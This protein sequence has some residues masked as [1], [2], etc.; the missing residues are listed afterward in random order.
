[1]YVMKQ[2]IMMAAIAAL[3]VVGAGGH[4]NVKAD[5]CWKRGNDANGSPYWGNCN[6]V[7]QQQPHLQ[8]VSEGWYPCHW[9]GDGFACLNNG[10]EQHI[11]IQTVNC[12]WSYPV[13]CN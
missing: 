11:Q 12:F 10:F 3:C 13:I 7:L 2:Y 4:M 8:Q 6:N 5:D 1:M 9:R